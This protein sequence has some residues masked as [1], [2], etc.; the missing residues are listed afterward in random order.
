MHTNKIFL[1]FLSC[2]II[3]S[4]LNVFAVD[5]TPF[6]VIENASVGLTPIP[7]A[8]W[9]QA[10]ADID[11]NGYPDIFIPRYNTP[12]F[13]HIFTNTNGQ[14]TD[15][16]SQSP[17]EELETQGEELRSFGA[18]WVDFDN[19]GDK[20]LCYGSPLAIHLFENDGNNNFT[21]VSEEWGFVGQKPPGFITEWYFY[22]GG[23]ADYD[24]DGDL[25]CIVMQ[26]N[27]DNMYL[28]RNDGDH[29]TDAAAE[30]GLAPSVLSESNRTTWFD[31]DLDGDPD[32]F[33]D[34]HFL[35]NDNGVFT[36][37][38]DEIG[39]S[40]LE[41]VSY[42]RFFDYDNDGD[43]DFFKSISSPTAAGTNEI[44]ENQDGVFTNVS[45]QVGLII[46]RDRFRGMAVGDFDN[47]GDVDVF[48]H[49]N[50]ETTPDMLLLNDEYE[51]GRL[52]FDVAEFAQ[53]KK[54]GDRKGGAFF[55]YDSDGFLDIYLPSAEY[56][57]LLYHNL[58][59]NGANWVGFTLEGTVSNRDAVG[60]I[61]TL[62][63]D[64]K[65]QIRYHQCG[66][67]MYSQD[68]PRIH[69]GL[70][71]ATTIDSVVINWPLGI[72][73]VLTDVAINQYHDVVESD[74]T[75]VDDS[76]KN[77]VPSA[78]KLEQNYPNPFNPITNIE[79]DIPMDGKIKLVVMDIT[80][81]E[82]VTLIDNYYTRGHHS[83][84]WDGKGMN[85]NYA[86]SGV[87]FYTLYTDTY[88]QTRKMVF[89]K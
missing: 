61:V 40:E 37:V 87:Y 75:K 59:T 85:G 34:T 76:D 35:R 33:S 63:A 39:F 48:L 26:Q 55:D 14:F 65:K 2:M 21:E 10:I 3:F 56:D 38:T 44:W 52:F 30:A 16:T 12:G 8:K 62:Y 82:I 53:V 46:N 15:I 81:R 45:E 6:E 17:I 29:F 78:F 84:E 28:F 47:D 77:L 88:T 42:R 83:C 23:W 7:C 64:G 24:L 74:D 43:F 89:I 5:L 9:G 69:F 22:I 41:E 73:Q 13:S 25:D 32:L 49:I 50:I 66:T 51:G 20:D 18:V 36:E 60:S 86:S 79:F 71:T 80:G 27:N 11:R 31:W 72:R 19:D 57:H 58:A 67:G 1:I 54:M 4:V 68:S 70:G